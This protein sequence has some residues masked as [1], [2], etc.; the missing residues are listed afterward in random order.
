[1][2]IVN[3][4]QFNQYTNNYED[5]P[6]NLKQTYLDAAEKIVINY[7]GYDPRMKDYDEFFSGIGDYKLY[8]N[9]RDIT[10]VGFVSVNGQPID[11]SALDY[12]GEYIYHRCRQRVFSLGLDNIHVIYTAGFN[13]I[14]E[15]IVLSIMRIAALMIAEANGNIGVTSK[16]FGDSSRTFINYQNYDKYLKP[17]DAYRVVRF[18]G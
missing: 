12:K 8:L 1:M 18:N 16:S 6:Q 2:S 3:V 17:L 4:E 13:E 15:L 11:I 10:N 5:D 7:L 14:P 9:A